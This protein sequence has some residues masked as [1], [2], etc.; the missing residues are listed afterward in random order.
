VNDRAGA[1]CIEVIP[2]FEDAA[3]ID[4]WLDYGPESAIAAQSFSVSLTP[5][6]FLREIA[7]ARTFVLSDEVAW[8]QSRGFG[9]HL[10]GKD[11][12]VFEKDGTVVDNTLRWPDEP[13]RHKILDCIG[14][15]ALS[16]RAFVGRILAHRSGHQLNHVMAK[17]LSMLEA[18]DNILQRAA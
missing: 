11:L 16:G 12:V 5:E 10:T 7:P 15:L 3:T 13:V 14:D 8:L 1:Q 2:S 17:T 6:Q 9:R 4:Y 18:C